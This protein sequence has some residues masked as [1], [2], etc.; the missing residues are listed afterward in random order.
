MLRGVGFGIA[1]FA[2]SACNKP[3]E[4]PPCCT[5]QPL[6]A[7]PQAATQPTE[8]GRTLRTLC[9]FRGQLYIGYGDYQENTGPIAITAWDPAHGVFATKHTS[10]TEAIYNLRV[11]GDAL[12][13]PATD[14]RDHADYAAGPPWRDEEPVHSAHAYDMA[15]LTGAD[16]WLVGSSQGRDGRPEEWRPTVWRSVERGAHWEIVHQAPD[17][18]RYYFAATFRGA[19]YVQ[20]WTAGGPRDHSE[21]FDGATWREGPN[22]LPFGGTG[23]RPV[24]LAPALGGGLLYATRH[25]FHSAYPWLNKTPNQL[26]GFDGA[27][28]RAAFEGAILDFFADDNQVIVL[29]DNGDVWQT[30]DLARWTRITSAASLHPHSV[31]VLD[32]VVY[33]GA[34][35]AE[36]Y[37][38]QGW[39]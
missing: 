20:A 26:L 11:I 23:V 16:L 25:T 15:S 19:L 27:T 30:T 8:V 22:L 10:D 37:R 36:L 4:R 13:A 14:R 6:G 12:Y 2:W 34:D 33:V 24:E 38:L 7:H 35:D 9:P 5:W 32:R 31:A 21:I 1:L 39:P 28:V 18:G 17:N 29:D 3:S